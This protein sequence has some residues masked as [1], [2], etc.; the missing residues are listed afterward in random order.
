MDTLTYR[1][2]SWGESGSRGDKGGGDEGLDL[3]VG[4]YLLLTNMMRKEVMISSIT[5]TD[6]LHIP[7]ERS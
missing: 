3:H 5:P 6:A 1:A 7:R 4:L 2:S